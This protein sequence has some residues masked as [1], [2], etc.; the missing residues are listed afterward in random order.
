MAEVVEGFPGGFG[1]RRPGRGAF[2]KCLDGRVWRFRLGDEVHADA[3]TA[4][5]S[6][7]NFAKRRGTT[8]TTCAKDGYFYVQFAT[9]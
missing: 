4:R 2:E 9:K 1:R 3:L 6:A 8:A 5:S 7:Y